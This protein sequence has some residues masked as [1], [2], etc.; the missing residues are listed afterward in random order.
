M[1]AANAAL[2]FSEPMRRIL[3]R[4]N[5]H[6][7]PAALQALARAGSEMPC[8]AMNEAWARYQEQVEA[9]VYGAAQ[10]VTCLLLVTIGSV[11]LCIRT[12]FDPYGK[13]YLVMDV[14]QESS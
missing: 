7:T 6:I 9:L 3:Q 10:P 8:D 5:S 4:G 11:R 1:S 13:H 12:S 2:P 14:A